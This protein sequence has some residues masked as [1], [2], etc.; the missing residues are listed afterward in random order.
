MSR[1]RCSCAEEEVAQP[2]VSSTGIEKP[3]RRREN[4]EEDKAATMAAKSDGVLKMKKSDVAFTPLQNSD[5]SG[6]VQGLAPG[7]QPDSGNR[8]GGLRQRGVAVLWLNSTCLRLGREQQNTRSGTVCGSSPQWR[9]I[10]RMWAL[11]FGC[12]STI[13]S[14]AT[15]G[16]S[17]LR[18]F[19][20]ARLVLR[21]GLQFPLVCQW[22]L[23]RGELRQRRRRGELL[24][25]GREASQ[26]LRFARR[27][28][29]PPVYASKTGVHGEQ[30]QHHKQQQ[31]QRYRSP[32]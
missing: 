25:H 28:W 23:H 19:C 20:G 31:Q 24:P 21:A 11:I 15:T 17:G 32:D 22:F 4:G 8:R 26:L 27:R 12:R 7:S 29:S 3:R 13:T 2:S 10:S 18:C 6:S 9:C 14:A 1:R 16:G 5:H 30:E